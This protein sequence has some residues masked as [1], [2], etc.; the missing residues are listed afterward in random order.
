MWR[1]SCLTVLFVVLGVEWA[2]AADRGNAPDGG[3][4]PKVVRTI[5]IPSSND[6]TWSSRWVDMPTARDPKSSGELITHTAGEAK[7]VPS[8]QAD[9]IREQAVQP[10]KQGARIDPVNVLGAAGGVLVSLAIGLAI[11]A[12][13]TRPVRADPQRLEP[14]AK[15]VQV[16]P[17]MTRRDRS[18]TNS[19]VPSVE[20][21]GREM[22]VIMATPQDGRSPTST[23]RQ[24]FD[25]YA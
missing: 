16:P 8:V 5:P 18:I 10:L 1:W 23:K 7:V 4:V 13:R 12:L 22:A 25:P 21:F 9:E 14:L 6:P 20:T 3:I 2:Q 17:W 11:Y 15:T 19:D 24:T